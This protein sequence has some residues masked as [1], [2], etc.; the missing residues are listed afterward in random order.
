MQGVPKVNTILV[1]LGCQG[2]YIANTQPPAHME[3]CIEQYLLFNRSPL[4]VLTDRAN[5]PHIKQRPNV[6]PVAIEDYASEKGQRF[7]R[8]FNYAANEF[9]SVS[10]T[11]FFYLEEFA[12]RHNLAP[13]AHFENDVLVYFDL[14]RYADTFK[15]LYGPH[16]ALTPCDGDQATSGFMYFGSVDA[17]AHMNTYF[18]DMLEQH[19][20]HGFERTFKV[21]MMNDMTLMRRYVDT[22]GAGGAQFLPVL[23][24]G[25]YSQDREALGGIFDPGDFGQYLG[26][27]RGGGAGITYEGHIIGG[28]LRANPDYRVVWQDEGS[29]RCPYFSYDDKQVKMNSLHIHSKNMVP[30]MSN[31]HA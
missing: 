18:V 11:R 23:P 5:L 7:A 1:H 19:G 10:T 30:F 9:W 15:Q 29:R 16:L 22:R 17:I 2:P 20:V 26:G 12:R 24:F 25:D 8:Q 14:E 28:V 4:Y 3:H 21:H 31:Y 6:Y 13:F 27:T